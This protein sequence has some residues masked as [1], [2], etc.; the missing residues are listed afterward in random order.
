MSTPEQTRIGFIG[1]GNMGYPM[2]ANLASAGFALIV[3]DTRD[4]VEARFL[5]EHAGT[6]IA[7]A[8]ADF[9]GVDLLI[10]MLPT[11]LIVKA[12]LIDGDDPVA[13]ALGEGT[14]VIDMSSSDPSDTLETAEALNKYGVKLVDAPVSGGV[15]R[16]TAG[17]LSIMVGGGAEDVERAQPALRIM[18][19]PERQFATGPL[20]SGHAMKALNNYV[21]AATYMAT[22]EALAIGKKFGLDTGTVIDI[23]NVSTGRSFVSDVVFSANAVAGQYATGF[24]LGLLAKDVHIAANVAKSLDVDAPV[25]ELADTRWAAALAS[26]G[27]T[28]DHSAAHRAWSDIDIRRNDR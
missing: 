20:G 12:A 22:A 2:A 4:D 9:A 11:G 5:K 14:V 26:E 21:A 17:D 13:A 24:Q 10:T 8:A 27:P 6:S 28:A 7:A 1:L 3:R 15:P 19:D 23:I 25:V 16:A 18:G